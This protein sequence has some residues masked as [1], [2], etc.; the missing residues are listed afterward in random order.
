M[1]YQFIDFEIKNN[2]GVLILKRPDKLNSFT[3]PML[4]EILD[5]L[6]QAINNPNIRALM[7]SGSGRGFGAGQDL[8]EREVRPG[9]PPPD[10]GI[11]LEK[12]YNPIVIKIRTM[13]IPVVC[14]VNGVAAGAAANIALA[15]DLVLAARSARF[16]EPFC[17]LGLVPDAGGTWSLPRLVGR[18]RAMGM[19]MLGGDI[20]AEQAEEWGLIWACV[21]DEKLMDEA[22]GLAT[23]LATQP[24]VGLGL[25]KRAI[26]E[27]HTNSLSEQLDLERD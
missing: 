24:T 1:T 21:D 26:N 27:S 2:V 6:D 22:L 4:E 10:L 20:S 16:I 25:I 15:C 7:L 8:S 19:A 13:G 11:S 17:R 18:A 12:R 23:R 9:D 5:A 14:A 3:V